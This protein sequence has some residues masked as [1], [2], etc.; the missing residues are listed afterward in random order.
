MTPLQMPSIP[1]PPN[2]PLS[3]Q[4]AAPSGKP[5][6]I[7]HQPPP[8]SASIIKISSIKRGSQ[9]NDSDI[10]RLLDSLLHSNTFYYYVCLSEKEHYSFNTWN[11]WSKELQKRFLP[12]NCLDDLKEKCIHRYLGQN[13]KFSNY[14]EDKIYLQQF[15]FPSNCQGCHTSQRNARRSIKEGGE[16]ERMRTE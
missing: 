8:Y 4:P 14:Y 5:S 13:K 12:P 3:P 15:L 2:P 6:P 11:A 7:Q 16:K 10:L 9:A 1:T